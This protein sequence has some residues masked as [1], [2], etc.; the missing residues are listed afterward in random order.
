MALPF[1]ARSNA[2]RVSG[3][4]GETASSPARYLSNPAVNML[5]GVFAQ[6]RALWAFSATPI[7]MMI[8]EE[9]TDSAIAFSHHLCNTSGEI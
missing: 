2:K 3:S 9:K 6:D 5:F 8:D 4:I 7:V 1:S